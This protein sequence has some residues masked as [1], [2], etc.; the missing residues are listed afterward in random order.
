VGVLGSVV[1]SS[2]IEDSL[3]DTPEVQALLFWVGEKEKRSI[4]LLYKTKDK[5]ESGLRV[6][7]GEEVREPTKTYTNW[8]INTNNLTEAVNKL[9]EQRKGFV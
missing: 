4:L 1:C 2:F 3:I 5:S 6:C 8:F 9:I 7:I